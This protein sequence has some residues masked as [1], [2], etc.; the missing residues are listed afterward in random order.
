[1]LTFESIAFEADGWIAIDICSGV[2]RG[3]VGV[4]LI[5]RYKVL[6]SI[7]NAWPIELE[8]KGGICG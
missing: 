4:D 7:S 3:L 2:W 1:M 5:Q 8:V 6:W